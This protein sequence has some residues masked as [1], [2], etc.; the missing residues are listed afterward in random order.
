MGLFEESSGEGNFHLE[1]RRAFTPTQTGRFTI[2][3]QQ[4]RNTRVTEGFSGI[5]K[6]VSFGFWRAIFPRQS[7]R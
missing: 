1:S 2:G 6:F 7:R 4:C 5:G 3:T